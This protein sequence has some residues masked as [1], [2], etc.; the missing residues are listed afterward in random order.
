MIKLWI[1]KPQGNETR[2]LVF[3]NST[4]A[5]VA[6]PGYAAYTP[7]KT[8][9]RALVDTLRQ[10]VLIYEPIVDIKVHCSFPGTILTEAFSREQERKPEICKEIEGTED[11]ENAMTAKQVAQGIVKGLDQDQYFIPVDF[12]TRLLLN[13]MRGPSPAETWG[14]DWLLGFIAS[15]VWPFFRMS[16]DRKTRQ[17]GL[18]M[19]R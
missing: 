4:A 15:L 17:Y 10:E 11:V 7:T 12:Q 13:N 16:F 14:W 3:T 2:H 18:K 19:K 9:L 6:L 5:F 8:A 1:D